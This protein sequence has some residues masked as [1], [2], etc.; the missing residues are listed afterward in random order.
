LSLSSRGPRP[1]A[2][3]GWSETT[4]DDSCMCFVDQDGAPAHSPTTSLLPKVSTYR[5]PRSRSARAAPALNGPRRRR[6]WA[7]GSGAAASGAA[8][9]PRRW[10]GVLV[11]D[12]GGCGRQ[13]AGQGAAARPPVHVGGGPGSTAWWRRTRTRRRLAHAAFARRTER[14]DKKKILFLPEF[15]V[16]LC[17]SC[18]SR[19]C[20]TV[21]YRRKPAAI[22][23]VSFI[24][25]L[26]PV[27][28]LSFA[29]ELTDH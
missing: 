9:A 5:L 21:L 15:L 10:R 20:H 29:V 6:R 7:T 28:F 11:R 4:S 17:W 3:I 25:I 26:L 16:L 27:D 13:V 22:V 23:A 24:T 2:R 14:Y 8:C 18:L 19:D 1:T 12:G